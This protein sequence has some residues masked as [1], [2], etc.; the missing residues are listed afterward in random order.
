MVLALAS[1]VLLVLNRAVLHG[2]EAIG[3]EL[4]IV[5]GFAMVGAVVAARRRGMGIGWWFLALALCVA[6][7]EGASQY[8]VRA[9][10]TAPGS[11]AAGVWMA[12]LSNATWVVPFALVG[13]V[14]LLFPD[15]WL[16]SP[17]WRPVAWALAVCTGLLTLAGAVDPHPVDLSASAPSP[18]RSGSRGYGRRRQSWGWCSWSTWPPWWHRRRLRSCAFVERPVTSAS[19]SPGLGAVT[20]PATEQGLP[21]TPTDGVLAYDEGLLI[22]YRWY[23]GQGREP[24]YR[25]GHGLGYTSWD[26]QHVG[27]ELDQDGTVALQVRLKNTG[28]RSRRGPGV[29]QPSRQRRASTS[30]M[31]RRL[32]RRLCRGRQGAHRSVVVP[33]RAFQHWDDARHAW[34]TEPGTFHLHVGPSSGDLPCTPPSRSPAADARRSPT[35]LCAGQGPAASHAEGTRTGNAVSHPDDRPT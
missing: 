17:R 22:G 4:V 33:L 12:W 5:P 11:L 25:F 29:R 6:V 16:P 14:L 21:T 13:F 31:A 15:G 24:R 32:C 1:V 9:L 26:Y 7:R 19:S 10:I 27:A 18:I 35:R 34:R 23:D 8:A 3:P 20:W 28:T 30:T 2:P